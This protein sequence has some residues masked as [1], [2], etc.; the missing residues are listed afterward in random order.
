MFLT[1]KNTEENKVIF[2]DD[3]LMPTYSYEIIDGKLMNY[4]NYET[5]SIEAKTKAPKP[6]TKGCY[7]ACRA[8]KTAELES[9]FISDFACSLSPCGAVVA[10]HCGGY[11]KG[12]WSFGE[13]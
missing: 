5:E 12:W 8:I 2:Y 7:A 1:Y 3:L 13:G 11:C 4:T 9:D 6:G 10:I